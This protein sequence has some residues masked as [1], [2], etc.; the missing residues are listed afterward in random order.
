MLHKSE[1]PDSTTVQ[2]DQAESTSSGESKPAF[3]ARMVCDLAE[4]GAV[5]PRF[6][7]PHVPVL[8]AFGG[9]R[10]HQCGMPGTW[11]LERAASE[12][13]ETLFR[14]V[15]RYSAEDGQKE[16]D[17]LTFQLGPR[18][19]LYADD[20]RIVGYA[21]TPH[22]A[23]YL[24][25]KFNDTY[26][27]PPAPTGGSF[28]LITAGREISIETVILGAETI[29]DDESFG[30]HYGSEGQE[31]HQDFTET[32]RA[33]NHGLSIFEGMPGTGKTSYLRYL[34]GV[35]KKSHR[36]YFIPPATMGV[37]SAPEFIGFWAN[38]RRRH[39]DRKFVEAIS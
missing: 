6:D 4:G 38:Q 27:K 10:L 16:W 39:A 3:P 15:R 22:E 11:D 36:F 28:H 7:R 32:V 9:D 26:Q 2:P 1:L 18:S 24:I 17:D 25:T 30:L 19:F 35:L 31:W 34:M 29:L 33:S 13:S 5:S 21:E 20:T 14:S 23:E 12:N 37:L 8:A